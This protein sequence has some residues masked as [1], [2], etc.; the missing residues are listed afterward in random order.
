MRLRAYLR[1]AGECVNSR[2]AS[3]D[4]PKYTV[5]LQRRQSI[6]YLAR[7]LS[8]GHDEKKLLYAGQEVLTDQYTFANLV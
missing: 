2:S 7:M 1:V 6:C 8:P 4:T 3:N 5:L